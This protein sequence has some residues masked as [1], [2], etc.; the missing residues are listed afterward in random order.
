MLYYNKSRVTSQTGE[1]RTRGGTCNTPL[2]F[3]VVGGGGTVFFCLAFSLP[4]FR[5]LTVD[6]RPTK[7]LWW[8]RLRQQVVCLQRRTTRITSGSGLVVA[9]A[10]ESDVGLGLTRGSGWG[11]TL[12]LW[13]SESLS[14]SCVCLPSMNCY[15][16]PRRQLMLHWY[17]RLLH[18]ARLDLSTHYRSHATFTVCVCFCVRLRACVLECKCIW[19]SVCVCLC[20]FHD[21][22]RHPLRRGMGHHIARRVLVDILSCCTHRQTFN[23]RN[24][25]LQK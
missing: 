18:P 23:L 22:L 25:I 8:A 10:G 14:V 7:E 24:G 13:Y 4:L 21:Y 20:V 11:L 2:A 3:C 17:S 1:P 12:S 5:L 6:A 15:M 9:L 19:E 16:L